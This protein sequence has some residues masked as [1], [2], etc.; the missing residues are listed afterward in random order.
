MGDHRLEGP[1]MVFY[2]FCSKEFP[3]SLG[4][5][6]VCLFELRLFVP[7]NNFSVMLGRFPGLN[8]Y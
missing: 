7:V 5:C 6:F 2:C 3:L 1:N 8:Q 4:V